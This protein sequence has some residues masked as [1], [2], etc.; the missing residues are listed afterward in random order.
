M[1]WQYIHSIS[2]ERFNIILFR[3]ILNKIIYLFGVILGF[4]TS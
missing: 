4:K 3:I 2:V 1:E